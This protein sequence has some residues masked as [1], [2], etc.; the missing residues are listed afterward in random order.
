MR[1][2][3]HAKFPGGLDHKR[4]AE[5]RDAEISSLGND[6]I[7]DASAGV[8][9]WRSGAILEDGEGRFPLVPED[10]QEAL[11]LQ[12]K[13]C[14][15]AVRQAQAAVNERDQR[16]RGQVRHG[17]LPQAADYDELRGLAALLGAEQRHLQQAKKNWAAVDPRQH[18][19][20]PDELAALQP[21][22]LAEINAIT[23]PQ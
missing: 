19:R 2:L 6:Q 3:D 14:E 11:L 7:Y 18:Q 4:A 10:E 16:L 9:R 5:W 17:P 23:R 8:T 1:Q 22:A 12:L 20:R 13:F 15:V 21:E